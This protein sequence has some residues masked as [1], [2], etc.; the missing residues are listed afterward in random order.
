MG[1]SNNSR[2]P[3]K[4]GGETIK[5]LKTTFSILRELEQREGARVTELASATGLSKGSVHKHLT[6]LRMNDFV[7]REN[8]EYRLSMR[9]LEVGG[10]VRSQIP[11]AKIIRNKVRELAETTKETAQFAVA[12]HGRAVIIFREAGS[13]GVYTRGRIGKRFHIHQTATG[14]AML[15]QMTDSEVREVVAQQGLPRLTENTITD[16]DHLFD[17]LAEIRERG[18]AINHDETT[19]GLRSIGVPIQGPNEGVL[20]AIA[21]VGPSN[22]MQGDRLRSELPDQIRTAVNE[23]ELNLAYS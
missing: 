13:Q 20:G 18:F 5:C 3:P 21:V 14:K 17:E 9:F 19:E 23:L 2:I 22:R 1:D 12:E 8:G 15:S 4:P 11:G 10:H 6:S 7:C 16:I